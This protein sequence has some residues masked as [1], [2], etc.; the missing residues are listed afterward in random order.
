MLDAHWT[1]RTLR[2][3]D[4]FPMTEHVELVGVLEPPESRLC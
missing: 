3:F 1:L 4:L 2:G